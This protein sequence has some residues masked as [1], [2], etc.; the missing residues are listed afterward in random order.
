MVENDQCS[1]DYE[2][3]RNANIIASMI[4]AGVAGKGACSGDSGGPL[5]CLQDNQWIQAGITSFG[6]PCARGIPEVYSRVSS[7]ENWIRSQ[8][9]QTNVSFVTFSKAVGTVDTA[10]ASQLSFAVILTIVFLQ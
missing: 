1:R 2:G 4:C 9:A 7:F 6:I 10:Y 3:V 8:V 5:Q